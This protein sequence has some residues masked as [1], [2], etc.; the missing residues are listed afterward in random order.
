MPVHAGMFVSEI[1]GGGQ[2]SRENPAAGN[3][4]KPRGNSARISR[5]TFPESREN[6]AQILAVWPYITN[7]AL[8]ST[9]DN[10]RIY[11]SQYNEKIRIANGEISKHNAEVDRYRQ[12]NDLT[13]VQKQYSNIFCL[14]NW[15]KRP[16]EY[17]Q[18]ADQF[19]QEYGLL[20]RKRKLATVKY[21]TELV[22]KQIMHIY[23]TQ[24]AK[25]TAAYMQ[26]GT[27]EA[28]PVKK[29]EINAWHITEL[30]RNEVASIDICIQTVRNHRERLEEAG[31]LIDYSF[32]G[33]EKGVRMAINPQ[34]LSIFDA[35]TQK[36][37]RAGNQ[38]LN[39]ETLKDFVDKQI[40]YK[41]NKRNIK[42]K[43]NGGAASPDKGTPSA[44]L[45][46]V[47]YKNIPRQGAKKDA[48]AAAENVKVL[49]LSERFSAN[50]IPDQE[51]ALRLSSGYY[52][53]Y[54]PIDIRHF[55]TEAYNGTL[56]R[57][58]FK[59]VVVQEFFKNAAK[60]Y[61]NTTP[62][63]G[64]WKKAINSW[65][66]KQ[67]TFKNG[68]ETGTYNKS[69]IADKLSEF[70]WRIQ[71]AHKWFMKSGVKTLYPSDYFDFS[72]QDPKEIGFEYTKKAWQNH[73]KYIKSNPEKKRKDAKK[74]EQRL[75]QIN[76]SKKFEAQLNR[77]LK[78][79]ISVEDLFDNVAKMPPQ[80]SAKLSETLLKLSASKVL[81]SLFDTPSGEC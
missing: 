78:N 52:N 46:F 39:P 31:V 2:N 38:Q 36:L 50:L 71:H 3:K 67:F 5:E 69:L 43:E 22:F 51:L 10:Y 35:K 1:F 17:N 56:T 62:Y 13:E 12:E 32:R 75:T 21:A 27:S 8:A 70:R 49:T 41:T 19:N 30:K 63:P 58:E 16:A 60:L 9:M 64:S 44:A 29:L 4:A 54:T 55:H 81:Y 7:E 66:E 74:A 73:L 72:R 48:P 33:H 53:S 20:V 23:S 15:G 6:E 37:A 80:Y 59:E 42:K 77:F 45:S 79:K 65:M 34:I 28:K 24:L 61:R 68:N 47:F 40:V 26:L 14:K 76:H 57:D 11:I 18:L 25:Q